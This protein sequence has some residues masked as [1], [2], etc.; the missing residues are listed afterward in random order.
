LS[1]RAIGLAAASLLGL[2]AQAPAD[3]ETLAAQGVAQLRSGRTRDAVGTLR[4]AI[5]MRP[6]AARLRFL[7]GL[8]L[9]QA[10][11]WREARTELAHVLAA[12]PADG[13]ALH[14][15]GL[16]RLKLGDLRGGAEALEESLRAN[17]SNGAAALTLA[18]TYVSLRDVEKAES[19]LDG[20]LRNAEPAQRDL[21]R[22]MILN[23]R[24]RYREAEPELQKGIA[25]DP[26]LPGLHN[27]LGYTQMLLGDYPAAIRAF[28]Q[29]LK[30]VPND[31]NACSNLG[32]LFVQER[33]YERAKPFV[34]EASRQAPG[35]AGLLYLAAQVRWSE[36]DFAAAAE[37]L[38]K[39]VEIEPGFRAAHVLL[40]RVYGRQNR[41]DD[42]ARQQT[43]I[44]RLTAAEQERNL[45]SSDGYGARTQPMPEFAGKPR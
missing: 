15:E 17:P 16:C 4:Q 24:G 3:V 29:E 6:E 22:G 44:A 41:P 12:N 35:N 8:A 32:W 5:G 36:R 21:L 11:D 40:A 1:F 7:L 34:T 30:L 18:T 10:G 43:I 33:E 25:A 38:E 27:Q 2:F 14:L 9:Y 23:V 37:A 26:R 13:Q 28:E 42:V 20:P 39:A 19:L 31:F 45:E